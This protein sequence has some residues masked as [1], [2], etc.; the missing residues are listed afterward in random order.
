MISLVSI[1]LN[2]NM[3]EDD[4]K[5]LL[6]EVWELVDKKIEEIGGYKN[7][8]LEKNTAVFAVSTFK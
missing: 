1:N 4:I 7:N 8:V 6:D 5:K 2:L 3:S